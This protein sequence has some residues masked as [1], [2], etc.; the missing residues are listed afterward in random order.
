MNITS[1]IDLWIIEIEIKTVE[2][3]SGEENI[4]QYSNYIAH[5]LNKKF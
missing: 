1:N 3:K 4:T 2:G 5:A